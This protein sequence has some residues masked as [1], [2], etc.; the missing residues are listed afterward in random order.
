MAFANDTFSSNVS[1]VPNPTGFYCRPDIASHAGGEGELRGERPHLWRAAGLAGRSG[2]RCIVRPAQDRTIDARQCV[3]GEAPAAS[4]AEGRWHTF[5]SGHR[6][7]RAR[8]TVHRRPAEPQ[9]DRRL[10]IRLDSRGLALRS[11]VIDL[12]S[13]RVVGWSMK[14]EMNAQ[15]VTDALMMAIWRRGKPDALLHHS[16]SQ[17]IIASF[18]TA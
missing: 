1:A 9:I 10:H 6:A 15:L 5:D 14:A 12:F 3:T 2:N 8:S 16:D 17:R 4:L 13:R 7:E 11:A 18:R